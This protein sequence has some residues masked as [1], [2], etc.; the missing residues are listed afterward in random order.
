MS[1]NGAGGAEVVAEIVEDDA[2]GVAEGESVISSVTTYAPL[3]SIWD[4][5]MVSKMTSPDGKKEWKC[6]WCNNVFCTMES[7]ESSSSSFQAERSEY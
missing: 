3:E 6:L 4:D 1:D 2:A 5:D 7:F